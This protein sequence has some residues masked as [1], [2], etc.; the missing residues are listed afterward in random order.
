MFFFGPV[1]GKIFDN[2]GPRWLLLS[3]T[4]LE[5]FGLMMTSLSS[6][7]YQFILAQG[8]T[9]NMYHQSVQY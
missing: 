4:I 9:L 2:Y 3:G 1:I 5:V 6:E 8:E 7:Y